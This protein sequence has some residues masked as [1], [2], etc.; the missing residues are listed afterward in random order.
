MVICVQQ[1]QKRFVNQ[2]NMKDLKIVKDT[3]VHQTICEWITD[4]RV[5]I[6]DYE[7]MKEMVLNMIRAG[8]CFSMDRDRLRDA[9]E[10]IAYMMNAEDDALKD[11]V[12]R[13]LE[14]EDEEDDED[15]QDLVRT[16]TAPQ[17]APQRVPQRAPQSAQ[18]EANE[19]EESPIEE[20]EA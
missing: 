9:M 20:I 11:R 6:G 19:P 17:R 3:D 5:V 16:S 4:K 12:L 8:H 13:S 18:E 14:Y 10:D 2:Y 1:L 7:D 15:F